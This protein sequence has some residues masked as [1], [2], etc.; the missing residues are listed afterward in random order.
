MRRRPQLTTAPASDEGA[1]HSLENALC[2]LQT[3]SSPIESKMV[4]LRLVHEY[5]QSVNKIES[6]ARERINQAVLENVLEI[7]LGDDRTADLMKRQLMRTECFL[8][9]ASMLDSPVLFR[10]TQKVVE[11]IVRSSSSSSSSALEVSVPAT[12]AGSRGTFTSV[13]F[14][15][16]SR[17]VFSSDSMQNEELHSV[18]PSKASTM[19]S[20]SKVAMSSSNRAPSRARFADDGVSV[21]SN[22]SS[23]FERPMSKRDVSSKSL[24]SRSTSDLALIRPMFEEAKSASGSRP[25]KSS[26]LH[27]RMKP[28]P[29]I[30]YGSD[31]E[32]DH[33]V[34]G[35]DPSNWIEHDRLLGYQKTRM[36]FPMALDKGGKLIPENRPGPDKLLVSDKVV[37]E[38][39][40]MKSMLSYVGDLVAPF[41]GDLVGNNKLTMN[42]PM[43]PSGGFSKRI[44]GVINSNRY[45]AAVKQAVQ[46]WTP[47]IGT[48]LP[49][50]ANYKVKKWSDT[51]GPSSPSKKKN[52]RVGTAAAAHA[53]A[54]SDDDKSTVTATSSSMVSSEQA[55]STLA[56]HSVQGTGND[57]SQGASRK[58]A[59]EKLL[60]TTEDSVERK[61]MFTKGVLRRLLKREL[62]AAKTTNQTLK[63]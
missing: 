21:M 61:I 11:D 27:R 14:R 30:F 28:R 16:G 41:K 38:Y 60:E 54:E 8:I 57:A 13:P 53:F 42:V 23:N 32:S 25:L 29:S 19:S 47:L 35:S 43:M 10:D 5:V 17:N 24:L 58:T 36:W 39:L 56:S 49:A 46:V 4:A 1:G 31:A 62:Y 51:H 34:P 2:T 63:E 40:Q 37:E 52:S 15:S 48:H 20:P 33:V 55:T 26:S 12:A 9:L 44:E 45:D 6:F 22:V 59:R 7:V 50:W 3:P 18:S